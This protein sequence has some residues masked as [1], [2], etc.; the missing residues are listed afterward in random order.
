MQAAF[1]LECFHL[2]SHK[3]FQCLLYLPICKVEPSF[4]VVNHNN[5]FFQW[6]ILT[7]IFTAKKEKEKQRK[8]SRK[9]SRKLS[10]IFKKKTLFQRLRERKYNWFELDR[11]TYF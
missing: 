3:L 11:Q 9:L 4:D 6:E 8:H 10:D 1:S 5:G 2:T 7:T